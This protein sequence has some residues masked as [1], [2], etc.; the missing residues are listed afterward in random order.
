MGMAVFSSFTTL[1]IDTITMSSADF[2]VTANTF[3]DNI[4]SNWLCFDFL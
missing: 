1:V 3:T 4:T 2:Y